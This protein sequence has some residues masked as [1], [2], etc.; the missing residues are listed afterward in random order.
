M[1]YEEEDR[2]LD[3]TIAL[4]ALL[5]D[6]E[7][8]EISHKMALRMAALSKLDPQIGVPPYSVFQ[9]MKA[10]YKYR[11][12]IVHGNSTTQKLRSLRIPEYE[13]DAVSTT[14]MAIYYLRRLLVVLMLHKRYLDPRSVDAELLLAMEQ[15]DQQG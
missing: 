2:I 8:Q 13:S 6:T 12:A 15:S 14:D 5:S 10:I 7:Q 1:R 4:E 11:S 9:H 3:A